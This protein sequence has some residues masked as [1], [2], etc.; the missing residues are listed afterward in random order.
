MIIM[1]KVIV[2]GESRQVDHTFGDK[3]LARVKCFRKV[4]FYKIEEA[5]HEL[6]FK[7]LFHSTN[8]KAENWISTN[9][10]ARTEHS[11]VWLWLRFALSLVC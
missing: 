10:N 6:T 8:Q 1:P 7:W 9:Q 3:R 2:A 5:C 11:V 4:A